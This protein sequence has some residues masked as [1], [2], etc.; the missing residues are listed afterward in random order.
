MP[1]RMSLGGLD[2]QDKIGMHPTVMI[3]VS[4]KND[5]TKEHQV[6]LKLNIVEMDF[7]AHVRKP[8]Y[9][10][11]EEGKDK[12]SSKGLNKAN[13][14]KT[15]YENVLTYKRSEGGSNRGF[16]TDGKSMFTYVQQR[17]ALSYMY[18]KRIAG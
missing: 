4:I 6:S 5:V 13:V 11:N 18:I 3:N 15:L 2:L 16:K 10:F 17:D 14:S 1:I 9:C 12:F 7:S 8:L